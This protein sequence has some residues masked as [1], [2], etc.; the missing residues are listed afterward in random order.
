M[1]KKMQK[2]TVMKFLPC[3]KQG[4]F[5]VT[6]GTDHEHLGKEY[7]GEEHTIWAPAFA[8]DFTYWAIHKFGI[9]I[10]TDILLE[11]LDL[12]KIT[13]KNI[14]FLLFR[15]C[16]MSQLKMLLFLLGVAGS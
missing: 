13:K 3:S 2:Q 10:D 14:L 11:T 4:K 5:I 15:W 16:I 6:I 12:T 9:G 1:H 7:E 8:V